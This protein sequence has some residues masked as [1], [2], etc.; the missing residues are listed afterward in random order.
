MLDCFGFALPCRVYG[1]NQS[2]CWF[3]RYGKIWNQG[4]IRVYDV[5]LQLFVQFF[6][7]FEGWTR[8]TPILSQRISFAFYVS[9]VNTINNFCRIHFVSGYYVNV[10]ATFLRVPGKIVNRSDCSTRNGKIL[11]RHKTN[12]Q[13]FL[14]PPRVN[15]LPTKEVTPP[16]VQA[17]ARVR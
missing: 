16:S 14:Y 1:W 12:V 15:T 6:Q 2:V 9:D 17:N 13:R 11:W 7:L 5:K 3:F 8:K 4:Q 10:M